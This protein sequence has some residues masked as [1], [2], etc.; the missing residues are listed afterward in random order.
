MDS[1]SDRITIREIAQW[2]GVSIA[3]VSRVINNVPGVSDALRERVQKVIDEHEYEP[4]QLARNLSVN[5][6][7]SMALFVYDIMNPFFS[8]LIQELNRIAFDHNY[9]LIICDSSN[10]PEREMRYLAFAKSIKAAGILLTEGAD[11]GLFESDASMLPTVLIDRAAISGKQWPMIT[12]DNYGGAYHACE[13]LI[14]LDHDRIAFI[15]GPECVRSADE[16]RRG[17]LAAMEDHGLPVGDGDLTEGDFKAESG[18]HAIERLLSLPE[19][20]TAVLCAN[21]L[22]AWGATM[23]VLSMGLKV[24]EDLSVIGFDGVD[25][26]SLLHNLTTMRQRID[27]IAQE[28]MKQ[29]LRLISSQE[30]LDE[31]RIPTELV[32][33]DT[34]RR[35]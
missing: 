25:T 24:P 8:K 35:L 12:S 3:T 26:C 6:S 22:M 33:G 13:Y 11:N 20:P 31:I 29:M 30:T 10:E 23:R 1:R 15:G 9:S 18:L 5:A 17:Y 21:D 7:N 19:P 34:C 32:I 14:S 27:L 2:S 28:A 4:S 16:R